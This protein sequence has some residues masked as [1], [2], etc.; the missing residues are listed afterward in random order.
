[1]YRW[2]Y[3]DK[4]DS[5]SEVILILNV[6]KIS[7]W[8]KVLQLFLGF[9]DMFCFILKNGSLIKA[10][11]IMIQ[12]KKNFLD[13]D[14]EWLVFLGQL[15]KADNISQGNLKQVAGAA[16]FSFLPSAS[17]KMIRISNRCFYL[18]FTDF[19]KIASKNKQIQIFLRNYLAM[20]N[21]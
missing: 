4:L 19:K 10:K 6:R 3:D 5:T 14:L 11:K 8:G 15:P 16:D 12:P 21:H 20:Y 18:P 2:E 1:M 13:E 7:I 9:F 17:V